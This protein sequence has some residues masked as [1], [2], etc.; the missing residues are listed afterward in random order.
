MSVDVSSQVLNR[1]KS[2]RTD[3]NVL[4]ALADAAHVDGVTWLPI[5]PPPNRP[6]STACIAARANCSKR[7]VIRALKRLQALGE[8]EVRKAQRG[9][10]RINVYRITV[11]QIA[12]TEVDY[13]RLPFTVDRPFGPG[14]HTSPGLDNQET[15]RQG[16]QVTTAARPGDGSSPSHDKEQDPP[17]KPE[18]AAAARAI[19]TQPTGL[20][21]TALR[22]LG[23]GRRL[24]RLALADPERALA[25][26][27]LARSEA[28][29]NLAGFV[30]AGLESGDWPSP[31]GP[32][33]T[34]LLRQL[35]WVAETSWR[36]APDH[37]HEIVDNLLGT[38]DAEAIAELHRLVDQERER[39]CLPGE[40]AGD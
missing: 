27:E 12:Q 16:D 18:A 7:E 32:T 11:G 2:T 17:V 13:D 4:F 20:L 21:A 40:E 35:A 3:R 37:A 1:S 34:A 15:P 28:S 6:E 38:L 39:R 9:H 5:A 14:D 8:L 30:I 29:R 24:K 26:I 22:S 36:L 10:C 25:W 23:A 33:A 31:R 19:E